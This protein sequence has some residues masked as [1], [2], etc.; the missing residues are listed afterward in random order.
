MIIPFYKLIRHY[1]VHK[2]TD[3]IFNYFDGHKPSRFKYFR[4]FLSNSRK[5]LVYIL[6]HNHDNVHACTLLSLI[7]D[8]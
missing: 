1:R 2:N 8:Y 6:V 3:F 5:S 4:Q 7:P